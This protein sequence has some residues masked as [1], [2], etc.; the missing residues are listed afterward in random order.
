MDD[1]APNSDLAH[2]ASA[3]LT[4]TIDSWVADPESDVVYAEWVPN[5]PPEGGR[6]AV[7]MLQQVREAT[8]V[9]FWVGERSLVA[10]A[11]VVPA[12]EVAEPVYRQALIRNGRS[13]RVN[14]ALDAEGALVLRSRLPVER[15]SAE[16][17]SYLLAEIYETIELSFRPMLIAGNQREKL[18]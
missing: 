14:F 1:L 10:E 6:W 9:W 13:F 3:I 2:A 7:R 12:P 8:T 5:A 18:P 11:Y 15:V 4:A 16:E 17:L